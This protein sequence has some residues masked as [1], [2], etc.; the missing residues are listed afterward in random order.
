MILICSSSSVKTCSMFKVLVNVIASHHWTSVDTVKREHHT[1]SESYSP[2][3]DFLLLFANLLRSRSFRQFVDCVF[4]WTKLSDTIR[5]YGGGRSWIILI[6]VRV[7]GCTTNQSVFS[8]LPV[9]RILC[10]SYLLYGSDIPWYGFHTRCQSGNTTMYRYSIIYFDLYSS[11]I[12]IFRIGSQRQHNMHRNNRV[13][14]KV[15]GTNISIQIQ[16]LLVDTAG[17]GEDSFDP[18]LRGTLWRKCFWQEPDKPRY[19]P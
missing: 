18:R 2:Y 9:F 17:D 12:L 15:D 6:V 11:I 14:R 4:R 7:P 13:Y 5:E 1:N 19:S 10:S 3:T 8:A 16:N